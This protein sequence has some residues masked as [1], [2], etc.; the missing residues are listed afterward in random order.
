MRRVL[1]AVLPLIKYSDVAYTRYKARE[2][3]RKRKHTGVQYPI[4]EY[5]VFVL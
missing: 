1:M 4:Y 2:S 5:R 3:A